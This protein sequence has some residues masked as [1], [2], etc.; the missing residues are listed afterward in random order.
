MACDL[1]TE[2]QANGL[3]Q[4]LPYLLEN[5]YSALLENGALQSKKLILSYEV[6][7]MSPLCRP[8][9]E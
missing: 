4:T 6:V 8:F 9:Y 5:H 1:L 7:S 3:P 2:T